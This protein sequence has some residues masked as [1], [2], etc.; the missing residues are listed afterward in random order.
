MLPIPIMSTETLESCAEASETRAAKTGTANKTRFIMRQIWAPS[1]HRSRGESE[2]QTGGGYAARRRRYRER[3]RAVGLFGLASSSPLAKV[4]LVS[5]QVVLFKGLL[6]YRWL[7]SSLGLKVD[8]LASLNRRSEN[9][10]F[11]SSHLTPHA[12]VE[13]MALARRRWPLAMGPD[14]STRSLLDPRPSRDALEKERAVRAG[15]GRLISATAGSETGSIA[16]FR[17]GP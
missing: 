8:P 15:T 13:S 11:I 2:Q 7:I 14:G 5:R 17:R 10:P 16:E 12:P 3:P 1:P 6:R 4:T 9:A